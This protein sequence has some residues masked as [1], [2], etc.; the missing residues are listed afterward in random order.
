MI[1]CLLPLSAQETVVKE[2]PWCRTDVRRN[3]E[4]DRVEPKVFLTDREQSFDPK[5]WPAPPFPA[6][7][8]PETL[9]QFNVEGGYYLWWFDGE[10]QRVAARP[11][12]ILRT[13]LVYGIGTIERVV[14]GSAIV[15]LG[16][17][18]SLKAQ[19]RLA[20]FR[21]QG[22]YFVPAGIL[23]VEETEETSSTLQRSRHFVPETGDVVMF[24]REFHDMQKA[25][26]HR[27]DFLRTFLLKN[28]GSNGYSTARRLDTA[29]ALMIYRNH[30]PDWERGKSDV[31]GYIFGES[32]VDVE[33]KPI[34]SLLKYVGMLREKYQ[35][36]RR[37]LP[38][39]G[40]D[41][42]LVA[43]LLAGESIQAQH[44][45]AVAAK[46]ANEGDTADVRIE[47]RE[48]ERRLRERLFD[49]EDE[50]IHLLTFLVATFIEESGRN[51]DLWMQQHFRRSQFPELQDEEVLL[52]SL[53]DFVRD[54]QS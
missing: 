7:I 42:Q 45:A 39:A 54:L 38:A 43:E 17:V 21:R 10:W 41:W 40:A 24:V 50:Q 37:T 46:E 8:S 33:T 52:E 27:D 35:Q 5:K 25:A 4:S 22:R 48:I 51:Q 20:V 47:P 12:E 44:L 18:H 29:R 34:S 13:G 9:L 11:Q 36:G 14:R 19:D 26:D 23:T 49:R 53:R 15:D 1:A 6:E 3:V 28:A 16:D 31:V 32:F 30:Y 2:Y